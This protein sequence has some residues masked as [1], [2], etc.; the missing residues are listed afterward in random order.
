MCFLYITSR[1]KKQPSPSSIIISRAM[2]LSKHHST[3]T[4]LLWVLHVQ[5]DYV[6]Y[7]ASPH[8]YETSFTLTSAISISMHKRRLN[9]TFFTVFILIL[10]PP[11]HSLSSVLNI[12]FL[13]PA[14]FL[15]DSP[16][17]GPMPL[18]PP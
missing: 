7:S 1:F 17:I 9:F 4:T 8:S 5:C 16:E 18:Q 13:L 15:S 2:L 12:P 14:S 6:F 3:N 11:C 10:L